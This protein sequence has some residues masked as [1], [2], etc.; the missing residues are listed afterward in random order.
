MF[1]RGAV[2]MENVLLKLVRDPLPE[3]LDYHDTGCEVA[4]ACLDCPLPLCKHDDPGQ[5][6][7]AERRQRDSEVVRLRKEE[8]LSAREI[9]SRLGISKRSVY[10]VREGVAA[11]ADGPGVRRIGG[12]VDRRQRESI[13]GIRESRR[14][15]L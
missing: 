1:E 4:P 13:M 3:Y 10:R 14:A 12:D 2:L 6:R 7:R 8:G 11:A 9:A 5:V 15:G